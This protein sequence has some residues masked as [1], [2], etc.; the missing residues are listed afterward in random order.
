[1]NKLINPIDLVEP[2]DAP[3]RYGSKPEKTQMGTIDFAEYRGA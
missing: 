2:D 3:T 1:M